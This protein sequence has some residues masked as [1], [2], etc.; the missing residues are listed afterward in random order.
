[1][2]FVKRMDQSVAKQKIGIEWK[3]GD[4]TQLFQW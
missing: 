1:M 4:G 2:S 3:N